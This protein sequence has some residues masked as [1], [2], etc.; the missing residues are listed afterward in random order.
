[1]V[2]SMRIGVIRGGHVGLDFVSGGLHNF[3]AKS[4]PGYVVRLQ[5]NFYDLDGLI[6][7]LRSE[8]LLV[9]GTLPSVI[10]AI[11]SKSNTDFYFKTAHSSQEV[12]ERLTAAVKAARI[13]SSLNDAAL[14]EAK[15]IRRKLSRIELEALDVTSKKQFGAWVTIHREAFTNPI[16]LGLLTKK[17]LSPGYN[18][19]KLGRLVLQSDKT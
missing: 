11:S 5:T 8:I 15:R 14:A 9:T 2:V 12:L 13:S 18:L 16:N 19:T 4:D 6:D 17:R 10:P 1:M 3:E 7:L